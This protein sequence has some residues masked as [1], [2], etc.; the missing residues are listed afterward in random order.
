[1]E[2]FADTFVPV[3]VG[4]WWFGSHCCP[5]CDA[6]ALQHV[7]NVGPSR[8]LCG[9]CRR[10]WTPNH[11]HLERVDPWTCAGCASNDRHDCIAL[12]Q[13]DIP[14][15]RYEHPNSHLAWSTDPSAEG[16]ELLAKIV[17][18]QVRVSVQADCTADEA[19]ALMRKRARTTDHRVVDIVD[20]VLA[21]RIW[22]SA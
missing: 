4:E 6:R 22:F 18:A 16:C 13:C 21:H 1:M 5:A 3:D 10:C 17:Q 11:G 19:L 9:N 2:V 20:A 12:L 14:T 15:A 8:W 7:V